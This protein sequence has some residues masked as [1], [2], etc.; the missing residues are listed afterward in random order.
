MKIVM[1]HVFAVLI[2]LLMGGCQDAQPMGASTTAN[3]SNDSYAKAVTALQKSA[4]IQDALPYTKSEGGCFA[5][6]ILMSAFLAAEGI[7]SSQFI[8]E[9]KKHPDFIFNFKYLLNG[10][11]MTWDYHVAPVLRPAGGVARIFDPALTNGKIEP[12]T[13]KEW[14]DKFSD[15]QSA[16]ER[17]MVVPGSC[18]ISDVR[19]AYVR[20]GCE[21][22][23]TL[24]SAMVGSLGEMPRFRMKNIIDA[25]RYLSYD[26][27]AASLDESD[28]GNEQRTR[29][30]DLTRSVAQTLVQKNLVEDL[31][32]PF[33]C[34]YA[35]EGL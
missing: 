24:D 2:A 17:K 31:E 1:R 8:V 21:P 14:L 16:P 10:R 5:R 25:C 19:S 4:F 28:K 6:A 30:T 33:T 29:L 15:A 7:A 22:L 12:M 32:V 26:I 27:K 13:E 23:S 11:M 34:R 20:S 18:Y 9:A 3:V 35:Q